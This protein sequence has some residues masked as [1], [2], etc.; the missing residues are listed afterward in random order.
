MHH[1]LCIYVQVSSYGVIDDSK[2]KM[3]TLVKRG[4]NDSKVLVMSVIG[5]YL[6]VSFCCY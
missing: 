4:Y 5:E 1:S 6:S 3:S 2:R